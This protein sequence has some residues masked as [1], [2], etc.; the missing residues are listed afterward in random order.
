[1][2][3]MLLT[4]QDC[5]SSPKTVLIAWRFVAVVLARAGAVGVYVLDVGR[6]HRSV[7]KRFAHRHHRAQPLRVLV[8]D[9]IGIGGRAVARLFPQIGAAPRA[10]A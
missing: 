7:A 10:C 6:R 8:G 2:L 9:A 4:G 5:A 3:L 1:M